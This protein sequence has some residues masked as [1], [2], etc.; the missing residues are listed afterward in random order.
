MMELLTDGSS[1]DWSEFYGLEFPIYEDHDMNAVR[2]LVPTGSFGLPN[3]TVLDRDLTIVEE[4]VLGAS[5][6]LAIADELMAGAIPDHSDEWPMPEDLDLSALP[7]DSGDDS[8]VDP[9]LAR[10]PFTSGAS[11]DG[12]PY[13]GASCASSVASNAG[14]AGLS[15]VLGLIGAAGVV[16][17]RR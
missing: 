4:Y 8:G 11:G 6:A 14:G 10:Q 1:N 15:L 9:T 13:G 12:S 5:N 2:G 3:Y 16:R 7:V 17:R